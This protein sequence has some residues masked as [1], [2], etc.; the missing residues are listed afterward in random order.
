MLTSSRPARR[1]RLGVEPLEDRANPTAS[2]ITA[3]FNSTPI[4]AGDTVWFS[5]VGKV[6]GLGA[7]TTS[8]HLNG[9]PCRSRPARPRTP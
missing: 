4:P 1:T 5:S 2:A 8:L 3:S 6:S 7:G 9:G